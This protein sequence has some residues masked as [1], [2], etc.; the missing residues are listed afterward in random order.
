MAKNSPQ[1]YTNNRLSQSFCNISIKPL[2]CKIGYF[3]YLAQKPNILSKMDSNIY[4]ISLTCDY[5]DWWRYNIYAS[6]VCYDEQEAIVGYV[7]FVDQVLEPQTGEHIRAKPAQYDPQR[8]I[9]VVS[10]PCHHAVLYLYVIANTFPD[11]KVIRDSP[12]FEAQVAITAGDQLIS[13]TTHEV[14]QWGGFTI[15]G[16]LIKNA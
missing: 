6:V 12:P 16:L 2:C 8:P 3:F 1:R 11:S 7:N 4:R 13:T 9:E 14:N 15:S 10:E 5:P